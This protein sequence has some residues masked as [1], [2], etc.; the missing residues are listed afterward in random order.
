[1]DSFIE[2]DVI[3]DPTELSLD[4]KHPGIN[5]PSYVLRRKAFFYLAR[6]LRLQNLSVPVVEYTQAEHRLWSTIATKLDLLHRK[7]ASRIFLEGKSALAFAAETIP[8]ARDLDR[9]LQDTTGF[10][11]TP[12]EGLLAGKTY[13][14]GWSEGKMP[15]TLFLRHPSHP[16]YTPE[17]DIVHDILGHVP[18]LMNQAYADLIEF[19]GIAAKQANPRQ[20]EELVR[21]YWFTVE[22]GLIREDDQIKCLGAGILSSL[23]EIEHVYSG[24]PNVKEF[25]LNE[26]INTPFDPTRLQQL[27][28]VSNSLAEIR[29]NAVKL[30][31]SWG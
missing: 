6:D 13:F 27:Y 25:N 28:F 1:M 22:Y 16:E 19:I 20:M 8:Q 10:S 21:F 15:V 24:I 4:P 29:D 3:D 14:I 30:V 7:H 17:P 2:M 11:L 18:P 5:D 26:V 9:L 31:E 12:A 23:A